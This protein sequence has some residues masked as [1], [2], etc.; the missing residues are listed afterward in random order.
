[1]RALSRR[2]RGVGRESL[3]DR[4][5]SLWVSERLNLPIESFDHWSLII[6]GRAVGAISKAEDLKE[7]TKQF[8]VRIVRMVQALPKRGEA[9]IFGRQVV[10]SGTS[11]AANY[12][13]AFRAR[14]K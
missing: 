11:V 1:M 4:C 8:A 10:R 13:A 2:G 7:R 12:R 3:S 9:R 5:V 6:G 14:S